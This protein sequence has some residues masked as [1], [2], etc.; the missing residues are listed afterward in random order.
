MTHINTSLSAF[1]ETHGFT[2]K[3][4]AFLLGEETTNSMVSRHET[5]TR[6]PTLNMAFG[7]AFILGA[8]LPE[9]YSELE[10]CEREEIAR[11]ALKL[12]EM[13]QREPESSA[14]EMKLRALLKIVEPH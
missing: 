9:L 6:L 14:R 12:Y 5:G 10:K 8:K 13:I 7:Y 4:V 3:E 2:Q 11:R 1:R